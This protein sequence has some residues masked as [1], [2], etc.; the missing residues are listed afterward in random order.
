MAI[1]GDTPVETGTAQSE[2]APKSAAEIFS[3]LET[4]NG[5]SED[6][7]EPEPDADPQGDP[8]ADDAD[9]EAQAEGDA[10]DAPDGEEEQA[11]D[12]Q[13][14]LT[15]EIDGKEVTLEEVKS[16]YLRQQDYTRKTM[17]LAEERREFSAAVERVTSADREVRQALDFAA[18]VVNSFIPPAPNQALIQQDPIGYLEAK[19]AHENAIKVMNHLKSMYSASQS[20]DNVSVEATKLE[21]ADEMKALTARDPKFAQPDYRSKLSRE[22]V[23]IGSKAYGLTA[24]EIGSI[25]SHKELLVLRDAIEYRKL[26]AK[27][28]QQVRDAKKPAPRVAQPGPRDAPKSNLEKLKQLG[29]AARPRDIFA[30]IER[31]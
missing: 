26:Q 6:A 16:G 8:E 23:E 11:D 15:V 1:E 31:G 29:S 18:Q 21:L 10:E 4:G 3:L 13:E 19:E 5:N 25:R 7:K 17:Q 28:M 2:P 27:T 12:T 20:R 22:A 24:E 30:A 14:P 9:L